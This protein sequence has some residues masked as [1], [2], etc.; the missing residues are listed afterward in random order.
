MGYVASFYIVAAL[1]AIHEF[2][3]YLAAMMVGIPVSRFAV[4]FG[5]KLASCQVGSAEWRLGLVPLGGYVLP[6]F[7]SEREFQDVPMFRRLLFY[8]GGPAANIMVTLVLLA[9]YNV[10]STGF[11]LTAVFV[12]PFFQ[13]GHCLAQI[14]NFFANLDST[15]NELTGVVGIVAQGGSY[16]NNDL[17]RALEFTILISLNLAIFN[18][19][20]LPVLDGGKVLFCLLEKINLRARR[21]Q[22]AITMAG[23]AGLV[24]LLLLATI[25]D[26][27]RLLA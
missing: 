14:F 24:G 20:P 3:H 10:V 17:L 27:K 19:L 15:W 4:G 9:V 8:L 26:L 7:Q 13:T 22:M 1:V 12:A 18:L 6:R 25:L 11:S 16:I 5:P 23:L 21:F 2:G